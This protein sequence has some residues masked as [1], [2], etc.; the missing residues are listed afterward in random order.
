MISISVVC[1]FFA[2]A[3]QKRDRFRNITYNYQIEVNGKII[4]AVWEVRH[5]AELGLPGTFDRDVWWELCARYTGPQRSQADYYSE[6]VWLG[7][8]PEVLRT[9]G[10]KSDGGNV[11][12]RLKESIKRLTVTTCLTQRT[13]NCPTS[14]GF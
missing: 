2:L 4:D 11:I 9:M 10:K 5:D 6:R 14:G 1:L 8:L 7:G 3:D 13:F 12:A